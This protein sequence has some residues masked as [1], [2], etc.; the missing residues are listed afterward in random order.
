MDIQN[1]ERS[2]N[3]PLALLAGVLLAAAWNGPAV[4][5]SIDSTTDLTFATRAQ[6]LFAGSG[7]TTKTESISFDVLNEEHEMQRGQIKNS[8]VPLSVATLQT[9]WQRAINACTSAGY[10]IPVIGTRISPTQQECINGE[11][12]RNYCVAPPSLG[13]AVCANIGSNRRTYVRDLGP[14]IGN[15]PTQPTK[16][17][18]DFGAVVSMNSNIR[19]GFEGS[20]SYD[21]GSV[22]IDYAAR[23]RL[24]IDKSDAAPGDIVTVST[25][26]TDQD[27]YLMTSRYPFFE[28]AL[29]M[30][31]YAKMVVNAEY[32][33][34]NESNGN[35]VRATKE[36]YSIDS[37]DNP[38]AI[39]GVVP[40]TNGTERLFGVRLDSQGYT[41]TILGVENNSPARYEYNLTFPFGSPDVPDKK[42]PKYRSP[43]SFS[44]ADFAVTAPQLDTPASPGFLCGDCVPLR[45]DIVNGG[46]TNTTPVGNRTLIGGITDGNGIVLPFVNDGAQ[47]VDLLRVDVDLDVVTV[48]AGVPLGVI[49]EDPIGVF[50]AEVNLLDLDL[51]TFI[52]ADQKLTFLPNLEV[53]LLFSTP[54]EVRV[55]GETEFST[56]SL[57]S[58]QVGETLEFRQPDSAV[59]IT[60]IYSVKNNGFSNHTQLKISS[61]IQET[62]GQLKIGGY[63]GDHL[64]DVLGDDPNFALLQITPTLYDPAT[65]WSSSTAP[66]S[67]AG[68]TDIPGQPIEVTLTPSGSSG[69]SGGSGGSNG[70]NGGAS[71]GGGGGG[72]IAWATLLGLLIACTV[73][74]R[75]RR[76]NAI[77]A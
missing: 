6:S 41:T 3:M 13:W 73:M 74:R 64:A 40:F 70:Q 42:A 14:G 57:V 34:V 47:D 10:T 67:L 46:L 1:L 11:I 35:Q 16:K 19:L 12:R 20:Y 75:T 38:D 25:S 44:L 53:E 39:D 56:V 50:A 28:L 23:A 72:S 55:S 60:P 52:S 21:L 65:I 26:F 22:D 61:A 15:K 62:L 24:T 71:G 17:P 49:I 37:R 54:T 8:Q 29:D 5:Q 7:N 58:L 18:Y 31:A 2:T 68:F 30:H 77:V 43:L 33:G 45:N 66:W 9:I 4:A 69:G 51:A 76:T 32:A 48:A 63:V 59:V 36:L 27:P